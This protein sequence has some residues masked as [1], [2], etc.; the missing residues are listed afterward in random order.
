MKWRIATIVLAVLLVGGGIFSA[1]KIIGLREQ[2]NTPKLNYNEVKLKI[3]QFF[4]ANT[5][6]SYYPSWTSNIQ[7]SSTVTIEQLVSI[8]ESIAQH[9]GNSDWQSFCESN[10]I[11]LAQ[12]AA[13][14]EW[15]AEYDYDDVKIV[16]QTQ[17]AEFTAWVYLPKTKEGETFDNLTLDGGAALLDSTRLFIGAPSFETIEFDSIYSACYALGVDTFDWWQTPEGNPSI[18]SGVTEM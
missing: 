2:L 17:Q 8:L 9:Y 16:Y 12:A 5:G 18:L 6:D 14:I 15:L 1:M 10:S 11:T 4:I 7:E 3:E 13:F